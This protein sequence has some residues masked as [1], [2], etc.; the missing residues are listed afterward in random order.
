V[1]VAHV[2]VDAG[3]PLGPVGAVRAGEARLL[4]ALV[5]QVSGQGSL[6]GEAR[7]AVRAGEVFLLGRG[8][9]ARL[10]SPWLRAWLQAQGQL[11]QG[12]YPIC[13]Q[14]EREGT[15]SRR[16]AAE[17][18]A[19][20]RMPIRP[21]AHPQSFSLPIRSPR[22]ATPGGHTIVRLQDYLALFAPSSVLPTIILFA[23]A[24]LV[25]H[26]SFERLLLTAALLHFKGRLRKSFRYAC[27]LSL[28]Q[29]HVDLLFICE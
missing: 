6:L 3:G 5:P 4:S 9:D 14:R 25:Y 12:L 29:A 2:V 24:P 23:Q 22:Y 11:R 13:K 20:L 15:V 18:F 26:S 21:F 10:E 8:W 1:L 16:L 19:Q 17:R 27:E 28:P 7:R